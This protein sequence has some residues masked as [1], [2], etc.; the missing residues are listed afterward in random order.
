VSETVLD[1]FGVECEVIDHCSRC[2]APKF[3]R[4]GGSF[5]QL[6]HGPGCH[7]DPGAWHRDAR[8]AMA[9]SGE[10]DIR[11]IEHRVREWG[12]NTAAPVGYK[13]APRAPSKTGVT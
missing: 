8:A 10:R 9:E 7:S 12:S 2:G 4:P 5:T 1:A 6:F 11:Q 3:R 13:Q